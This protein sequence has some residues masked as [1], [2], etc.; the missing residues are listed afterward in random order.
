MTL[1][2]IEEDLQAIAADQKQ[3]HIFQAPHL[4]QFGLTLDFIDT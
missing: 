1:S 3:L 4:S 2:V